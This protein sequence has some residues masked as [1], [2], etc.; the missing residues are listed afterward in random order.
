MTVASPKRRQP[1]T[2]TAKQRVLIRSLTQQAAAE[3]LGIKASLLR[4]LDYDIECRNEDGTYDGPA[5]VA[6]HLA[7]MESKAVAAVEPVVVDVDELPP[8]QRLEL[9]NAKK[10]ELEY[11]IMQGQ[12]VEKDAITNEFAEMAAAVRSELESVAPRMEGD[13]PA[14]IRGPFI[15]ELKNHHRHILRRLA[16]RGEGL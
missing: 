3:L 10:R 13:L 14:E 12:F 11:E 16:N 5:L 1:A 9:A 2:K 15:K 6:V 8:K 4:T 7:A